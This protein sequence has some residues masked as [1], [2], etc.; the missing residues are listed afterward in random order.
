MIRHYQVTLFCSTGQYK[1]VS[2]I[3][4]KDIKSVRGK[5]KSVVAQEVRDDGIKKICIQR[6]WTIDD[7]KRY[8]YR[9]IKIRTIEKRGSVA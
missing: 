4:T 3:V 6:Y 5:D 2:T 8:G 1:P 7:L 9:K